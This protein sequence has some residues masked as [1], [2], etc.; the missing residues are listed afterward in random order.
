MALLS[1]LQSTEGQELVELSTSSCLRYTVFVNTGIHRNQ[2]PMKNKA[3]HNAR[4]SR[5]RTQ[6]GKH[7]L[8]LMV[9]PELKERFSSLPGLEDKTHAERLA[10]LC[11][12]WEQTYDKG[13]TGAFLKPEETQSFQSSLP[14]STNQADLTCSEDVTPEFD[15]AAIMQDIEQIDLLLNT[16]ELPATKQTDVET[17]SPAPS[18]Q[19][20]K[21][22]AQK[23][24]ENLPPINRHSLE[25]QFWRRAYRKDQA[26]REAVDRLAQQTGPGTKALLLDNQLPF[27]SQSEV[28]ALATLPTSILKTA[29]AAV[30]KGE[31]SL[32]TALGDA[33]EQFRQLVIETAQKS[34]PKYSHYYFF[35][36]LGRT[37]RRP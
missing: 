25:V 12:I 32:K 10:A 21:K 7:R 15:Y 9:T 3:L 24:L 26:F 35:E 6:A 14:S 34:D 30:L 23:R 29:I 13:Q 31:Q 36:E 27:R 22:L 33:A 5:Y 19:E 2:Q 28:I 11:D 16:H 20:L 8:E 18:F 1:C 37:S 4:I 17:V